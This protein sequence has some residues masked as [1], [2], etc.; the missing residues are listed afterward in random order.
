MIRAA[1]ITTGVVIVGAVYMLIIVG[2]V[3]PDEWQA[4]LRSLR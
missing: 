4:V 3:Q 2:F 1:L